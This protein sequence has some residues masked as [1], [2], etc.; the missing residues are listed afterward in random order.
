MRGEQLLA[1]LSRH[2]AP[3]ASLPLDFLCALLH[4][5]LRA[6]VPSRH[7]AAE[8]QHC[9]VIYMRWS[10]VSGA[11]RG[12]NLV[13]SETVKLFNASGQVAQVRYPS[14]LVQRSRTAAASSSRP[15]YS[16]TGQQYL[17][18]CSASS[19]ANALFMHTQTNYLQT[20]ILPSNTNREGERV[21]MTHVHSVPAVKQ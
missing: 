17:E 10:R 13:R 19:A 7:P 16:A 12:A 20:H 5:S 14:L 8:G 9:D 18:P 1:R 11:R 3:I 2:E 6:A 21:Q 4:Q 15:E